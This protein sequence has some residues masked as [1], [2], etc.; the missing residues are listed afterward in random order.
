MI[1]DSDGTKV[2]VG[3]KQ[4]MRALNDNKA[5]KVFLAMDSDD[6]IIHSV[7][8]QCELKNIEIKEIDTMQELGGM[9]RIEVKASCAAVLK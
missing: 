2:Y 9:C 8:E 7:K 5:L 6:K 3:Y 1:S 4:T